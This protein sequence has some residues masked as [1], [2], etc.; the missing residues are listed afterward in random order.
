VF[1]FDT[2]GHRIGL[3]RFADR[4]ETMPNR[5]QKLWG[6]DP[7]KGLAIRNSADCGLV[8]GSRAILGIRINRQFP[9]LTMTQSEGAQEVQDGLL[10]SFGQRVEAAN[11]AVGF[12]RTVT[13]RMARVVAIFTRRVMRL[14]SL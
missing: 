1:S 7:V 6:L 2:H 8:V 5:L 4:P 11:D 10:V 14:N 13:G 12:R 3:V 9:I